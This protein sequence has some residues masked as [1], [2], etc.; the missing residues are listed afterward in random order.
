M[1]KKVISI[2][3]D[4]GGWHGEKN[5]IC[6]LEYDGEKITM[7]KPEI[8]KKVFDQKGIPYF[9]ETVIKDDYKQFILAI[10]APLGLPVEFTNLINGNEVFIPDV[11]K[12]S[13]ENRLAFR[14]TDMHIKSILKKT[15]ISP[16]FDKL[17]NNLTLALNMTRLLK[18]SFKIYPFHDYDS[19]NKN[20]VIEVYPGI[21]RTDNPK[22]SA[23]ND[24]LNRFNK[25]R[26][27]KK[28]ILEMMIGGLDKQFDEQLGT[29]LE[30]YTTDDSNEKKTDKADAFICSLLG[31]SFLLGKEAGLPEISKV[32][33]QKRATHQ[34]DKEVVRKEGWIYYPEEIGM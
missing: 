24:E 23:S 2:G 13:F 29:A 30:Y 9:I 28:R 16:S 22:K 7:S 32:I 4:V 12:G 5:A 21:F 14:E 10:D 31:L 3:W 17:T 15:P 18:N 20:N 8:L 19:M 26:T 6:K 1:T 33:P 25:I 34:I 11:E 27:S